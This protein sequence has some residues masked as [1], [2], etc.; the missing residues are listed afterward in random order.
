MSN[1][2]VR[3]NVSYGGQIIKQPISIKSIVDLMVPTAF[4]IDSGNPSKTE[5]SILNV[6]THD[7][8]QKL[9]VM[10]DKNPGSTLRDRRKEV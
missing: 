2:V 3:S 1:I 4:I 9:E 6:N 10:F 8:N 5:M 7:T